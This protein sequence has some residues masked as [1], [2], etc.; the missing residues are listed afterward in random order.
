MLAALII[1]VVSVP[2]HLQMGRLL[3]G[4]VV[5]CQTVK[6]QP[7]LTNVLLEFGCL[8]LAIIR[9]NYSRLIAPVKKLLVSPW[10]TN[11]FE[12]LKLCSCADMP[13]HEGHVRTPCCYVR[14]CVRKHIL[15]QCMHIT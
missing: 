6:V 11:T 2:H 7:T 12:N 13:H 4:E 8:Y 10:K 5:A 9:C 15:K 3:V 14:D 1:V